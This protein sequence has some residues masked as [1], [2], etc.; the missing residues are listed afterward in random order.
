MPAL[1]PRKEALRD[2][3]VNSPEWAPELESNSLA[4]SRFHPNPDDLFIPE[5]PHRPLRRPNPQFSF[6]QVGR[7]RHSVRA[8][9]WAPVSERRARSDTPYRATH[10]RTVRFVAPAA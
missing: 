7:A 10:P 2:Y 9:P 3:F 4:A 6:Y 8:S 1:R 5:P